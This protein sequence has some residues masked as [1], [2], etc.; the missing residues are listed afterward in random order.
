MQNH[1]THIRGEILYFIDD[2]NLV[3]EAAYIHHPDG[4]LSIKDGVI[5]ECGAAT[6]LLPHVPA[7]ADITHYQHHLIF[8]GLIDSHVHY[9]QCDVIASYG[10]QLL[11]WLNKYTFPEEAK[12]TD[13]SHAERVAAF[14]FNEMLRNGTTSLA[15]FCTSAVRSV[16][17]FFALAEAKNMRVIGGKVMM[18]RHAPDNLRDETEQSYRDSASLIEK[19][20]GKGRRHYAV[21]PRFAV[22]SS[23]RQ[24]QLAGQL[25]QENP[26]V[27]LQSHVAENLNEVAMVR[28]AYPNARS[29]LDVYDQYGQLGPRT[30]MAHGIWLDEADR[31][32][33]A[34]SGTAIAFCP[35]SNLFLGS[36][37]FDLG[38]AQKHGINV[39]MATDVGGGTSFSLL[40]TLA[41]GYKVLQLN[42]HQNFTAFQAFYQATLG[43]ARALRL[44]DKIGSFK[45][46]GEADFIALDYQATPLLQRRLDKAKD[47][48]ERLF[49][50]MI[51][52]DDRAIAA[53]WIMGKKLYQREVG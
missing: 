10:E 51:L 1:T 27:Y 48:A 11:T 38:L 9:P 30:I 21:T 2:P 4:I 49:A 5:T 36:G 53:T 31:Q 33:M 28:K 47:L 40:Q 16:E 13:L 3:G 29:Y 41:A 24:M 12:F 32:R 50:L 35:T 19:Y 34:E 37:L 45:I 43:G 25:Y 46:G 15:S 52:A 14:F 17:A 6:D 26:G 20:H 44:E 8:P 7:N 42:N 18:D 23:P 39:A 22:T